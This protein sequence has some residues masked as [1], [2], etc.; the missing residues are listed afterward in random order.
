MKF[1]FAVALATAAN[2]AEDVKLFPQLKPL[3]QWL[4]KWKWNSFSSSRS[5]RPSSSQHIHQNHDIM[6]NSTQSR[7]SSMDKPQIMGPPT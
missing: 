7:Y 5:I 1:G 2:A 6:A 4:W 3:T